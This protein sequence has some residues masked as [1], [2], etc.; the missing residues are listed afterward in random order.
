[1]NTIATT[2]HFGARRLVLKMDA[3][4][5]DLLR[6]AAKVGG[7]IIGG[8]GGLEL[9]NRWLARR[10]KKQ[11]EPI[12]FQARILDDGD[13]MRRLLL[14]E[15][16]ILRADN[17]ASLERAHKAELDL[18]LANAELQRMRMRME[19]KDVE[20]RALIAQVIQLGAVPVVLSAPAGRP[21]GSPDGS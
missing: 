6:D 15:N 13:E 20:G 2:H 9:I 19:R 7:S 3:A 1:V 12:E 5:G 10:R 11:A 4:T 17:V 21:G 16:R 14:D 8:A 18:A